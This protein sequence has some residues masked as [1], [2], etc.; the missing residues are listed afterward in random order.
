VSFAVDFKT[1]GKAKKSH[2]LIH[3]IFL[4]LI[5]EGADLL[6]WG[7]PARRSLL[8]NCTQVRLETRRSN[9]FGPTPASP[10]FF[11]SERPETVALLQNFLVAAFYPGNARISEG[12]GERSFKVER[13]PIH[14]RIEMRDDVGQQ[15]HAKSLHGTTGFV[16]G[17]VL[18]EAPVWVS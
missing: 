12:G 10:A 14:Q 16:T 2:A 9:T 15:A 5:G 8:E 11:T 18:I 7:V 17:L 3:G 13:F 6:R 1:F 4:M